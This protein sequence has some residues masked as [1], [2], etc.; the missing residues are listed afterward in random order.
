MIT[1]MRRHLVGEGKLRGSPATAL[2]KVQR[3]GNPWGLPAEDRFNWREGL[4]VPTVGENPDF[5][6]LYWVGCAAAY[7]RRTQK[8][9]RAVVQLLAR[10]EVNFA[11]LGPEERCSGDFAR[12]M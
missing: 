5:E 6:L 11:V 1:D 7:D 4:E 12:R 2:Q 3:S 8:I 10:A 9:A